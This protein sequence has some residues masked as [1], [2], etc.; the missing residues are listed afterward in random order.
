MEL[1]IDAETDKEGSSKKETIEYAQENLVQLG[2]VKNLE[3]NRFPNYGRMPTK[4]GRKS[5][6]EFREVDGKV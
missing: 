4:R 5:L 1:A 6:K 3:G 2:I